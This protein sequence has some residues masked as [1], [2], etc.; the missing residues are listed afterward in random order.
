VS[1]TWRGNVCQGLPSE[2]LPNAASQ[3]VCARSFSGES[4][5]NCDADAAMGE[6]EASKPSGPACVYSCVAS[7][8]LV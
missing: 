3:I 2:D 8:I 7:T 4:A 6:A 5:M 1:T